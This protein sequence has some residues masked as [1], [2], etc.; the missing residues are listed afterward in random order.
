VS[1]DAHSS[2]YDAD[3]ITT[4]RYATQQ[5]WARSICHSPLIAFTR[6]LPWTT[7]KRI[8]RLQGL[9]WLSLYSAYTV[10][11]K[12]KVSCKSIT[13]AFSA[14]P[15][16]STVLPNQSYR[17]M[18]YISRYEQRNGGVHLPP[19]DVP[20]Q[21][22]SSHAASRMICLEIL[23]ELPCSFSSHHNSHSKRYTVF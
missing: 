23:M 12:G 13:I 3:A 9:A 22:A 11:P 18:S 4:L 15:S 1:L 19:C 14:F 5:A 2:H 21:S 8:L 6:H 10:R 17:I 20:V 16:Y 7:I